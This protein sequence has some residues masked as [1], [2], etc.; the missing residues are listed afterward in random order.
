MERITTTISK[1]DKKFCAERNLHFSHL[2]RSK[3]EEMRQ[4]YAENMTGA[5][6]K[7]NRRAAA[8][9]ELLQRLN[10]F[11]DQNKLREKFLKEQP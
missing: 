10:A 3:I 4:G 7:V 9:E 1:V 8:L 11:I 2:L 6:V 5:L